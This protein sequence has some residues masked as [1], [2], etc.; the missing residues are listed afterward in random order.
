MT[1]HHR[2][3]QGGSRNR[4]PAAGSGDPAGASAPFADKAA[5]KKK[6]GVYF[7]AGRPFMGADGTGDCG[8]PQNLFD[9]GTNTWFHE[10]RKA[11]FL[12]R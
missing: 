11:R 6:A 8:A 7:L 2:G 12:E 4:R 1:N 9:I 10:T 5:Q 3:P